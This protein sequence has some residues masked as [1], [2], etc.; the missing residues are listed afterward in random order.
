[1]ALNF[2]I[3]PP[4]LIPKDRSMHPPNSAESDRRRGFSPFSRGPIVGVSL[5]VLFSAGWLSAA[6]WNEGEA[7]FQVE[8]I[9][10]A[11]LHRA[12]QSGQTTCL[13]V[14]DAFVERARAYNGMCTALVTEDGAPV[15]SVS[16]PIRAGELTWF[17]SETVAAR[18]LFPD[19]DRYEGLPLEFGRMEPTVSDPAVHAQVGMRVG[20]PNAGQVNALETLNLRGERSV[21]CK[22]AFDAHPSTGPLPAGAPPECEEFRKL[23]DARERAAEL[24]AQY[25]TNP[26]LN[27]LPLYCVTVA[28]KDPYDTKDMRTTSNSDVAFAMDVPPSDAPIIAGLREKGAILY[29]KSVAHEFNA[30]PGDPGGP[31]R[32]GRNWVA[33]GQAI[34]GWSG[35]ACNPYDTERVPRG[36]SSGSGVA[37]GANLAMIGICEQTGASCQGP[38]SRNGIAMLLGSAGLLPGMGGIGNQAFIDRPGIHARTLTDAARVLDALHRPDRGYF[39]EDVLSAV[40]SAWIPSQPFA[41]NAVS[42]DDLRS[43]PR[44]L[45]GLRIGIFREYMLTPTLNHVAISN[46]IDREIREVLGGRLGAELIEISHPDYPDDPGIPNATFT[47]NDALARVLPVLLPEVFSRRD[48]QGRLYFD[49]P[50]WDVTSPEYLLALARGEAP[51]TDAVSLANFANFAA[52]PCSGGCR[53]FKFDLDRYLADRGDRKIRTLEDWIGHARFRQDASLVAAENWTVWDG[54]TDPGRADQ[55]ARSQVGRI[56]LQV[57]MAENGI[58]VIVHP[59]NVVPTP[60]IQGPNVGPIS[61]DGITPFLSIPRIAVPA[62]MNDIVYEPQYAL[63]RT[64]TDYESVLPEGTPQTRLRNPMPTSI[65]FFANQ[66]DESLLIR[67][68]TAYE[69]AT[70][71]RTPPPQFG[72]VMP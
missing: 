64:R 40:P 36:S 7:D 46:Q 65:T 25:G 26:D 39:G 59:E 1:L 21:T 50:G 68:G 69:A 17:A 4:N 19:L 30:G 72:P 12:I 55:L 66:G 37:I 15:E 56:A 6:N 14:V 71:H 31:N 28:V 49:V 47:F 54:A 5:A 20:I 3:F 29:A 44:P 35:Q 57:M 32:S 27:R 67:V 43:Q 58:D 45:Q 42:S 11:D 63:N 8:E 2:R 9:T 38:A 41:A 48:A 13:A 33:G 51:L 22:G 16:G 23:P 10:I 62:G 70:G 60:K 18:N 24:D 61:Q 53:N 52:A 34:S